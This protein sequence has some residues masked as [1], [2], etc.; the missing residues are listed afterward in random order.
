MKISIKSIKSNGIWFD[1]PGAQFNHSDIYIL[2]SLGISVDHLFSYFKNLKIFENVILK[3]GVQEKIISENHID[4]ILDLIPNFKKTY[5]YIPG[6]IKR[7]VTNVDGFTY[8]GKKGRTNYKIHH[9]SG[10]YK[11]EFL[12][13]IAQNESAKTVDFLG[14]GQFSTSNKHIFGL[15]SLSFKDTEWQQNLIDQI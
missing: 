12:E 3:K 4:E 8:E 5:G 2:S 6:F 13:S 9:Y 11:K 15:K 14:I 10:L 7:E 1:I